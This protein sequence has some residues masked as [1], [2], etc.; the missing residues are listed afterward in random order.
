VAT[1][2]LAIRAD[3]PALSGHFPGRPI[4]PGVVLLD[5]IIRAAEAKARA[6]GHHWQVSYIPAVKFLHPLLPGQVCTVELS[7]RDR[8]RIDFSCRSQGELIAAGQLH[9]GPKST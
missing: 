8:G 9:G 6:S 4:V 2:E 1:I 3:H 7:L 5:E